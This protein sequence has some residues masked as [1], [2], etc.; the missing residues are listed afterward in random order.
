M[1]EKIET[2]AVEKSPMKE[3]YVLLGA[4]T[5]LE[6]N[7]LYGVE[8][9]KLMKSREWDYSN[10]DIV[11]NKVKEIIEATDPTILSEDEREWGQE[12][13]WFWYHHAISCA[14]SRYRDKEAA[15][16]Y[17]TKALEN[18]SADHPNK[19]TKLLDYLLNDKLEE[20]ERWAETIPDE[21]EKETADHTIQDYKDGK[22]I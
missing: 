19:I 14:I 5:P 12:I 11:I 9:Q 20:A 7:T 6:L 10:K 18:Q 2:F 16:K 8:D 22:F 1:S 4:K 17:V 13:L 15:L 21:V 3:A